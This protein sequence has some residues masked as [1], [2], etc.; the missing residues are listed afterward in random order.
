V[1]N[2]LRKKSYRF[3]TVDQQARW[4]FRANAVTNLLLAARGIVDPGGMAAAFGEPAPNYPFLIRLWS[5]LVL[6]F[7]LMFWETSR[8]VRGKAALIK[9]NW[10]EKAITATAVTLGYAGGDVS[11]KLM[12]LIVFTNWLWI[13]VVL[14]CDLRLRRELRSR[15][16]P[17]PGAPRADGTASAPAGAASG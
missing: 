4:V 3:G 8:D 12:L 1:S 14:Y 16:Q 11:A 15:S 6:M 13:P 7:G 10:A 5:G 2:E 9:Y 17:P